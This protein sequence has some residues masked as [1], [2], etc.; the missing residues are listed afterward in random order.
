MHMRDGDD[1]NHYEYITIIIVAWYCV[2]VDMADNEQRIMNVTC[3]L[4]MAQWN[5]LS[6]IHLRICK[7]TKN[8]IQNSTFCLLHIS[9]RYVNAVNKYDY[10]GAWHGS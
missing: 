7:H 4:C 9:F 6:H 5:T 10:Y 3:L 2:D 8:P 1:N